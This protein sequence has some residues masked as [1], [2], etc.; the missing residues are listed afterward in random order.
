MNEREIQA[1]YNYLDIK[2]DET[3]TK[4]YLIQE[5]EKA[6]NSLR[7]NPTREEVQDISKLGIENQKLK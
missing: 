4:E 1:A 3:L 2:R 5:T 6:I 7:K